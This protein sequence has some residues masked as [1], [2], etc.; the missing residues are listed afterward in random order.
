MRA[1]VRASGGNPFF[2]RE[3]LHALEAEEIE[4]TEASAPRVDQF[5][6]DTVL[7]AVLAHLARF[8]DASVA[9]AH[10][11]SVLGA[12]AQLRHAADLA[13][14]E[15]PVAAAGADALAAAGIFG[16]GEPL[17]YAHPLLASAVYN[18]IPRAERGLLHARAARVIASDSSP[19]LAASHLL[20]APASAD[21]WA[22]DILREAGRQ[23]L[24]VGA[25][26]PAARYLERALVEP[27]PP[28]L[29][30]AVLVELGEAETVAGDNPENATRHL[31]EA[32]ALMDDPRRRAQTI[33]R[34]GWTLQKAGRI[35]EAADVFA[36]GLAE[37][38]D[39]SDD[40]ATLLE[41]GY[42][43]AAW[44]DTTRAS[45]IHR[46]RAELLARRR[47]LSKE[48][49]RGLLA[50][51]TV[52][53][54][55]SA[56]S[57]E[58]VIARA[59]E[60][61][62]GGAL[63]DD[64]SSDSP[65]LWVAVGNLTWAD[66]LDLAEE[67][68]EWALEDAL[69][70]GAFLSAAMGYCMRAWP[71][72]YRGRVAEA[73]ADAQIALDA[74]SGGWGMLEPIARHW[75]G[76][77]LIEL[78]DLDAAEAALETE[79]EF[80]AATLM[81]GGLLV[82]RGRLALVRAEPALALE[83]L[84][85][86]GTIIVDTFGFD[87]PSALSWRSDAALAAAQLG[88][89]AAARAL[90]AEDLSVARRFGAPRAIGAS[91]RAAGLVEGGKRGAELLSAAVAVLEASPSRL[92]LARALVDLGATLRRAGRRT[93]ARAPLRQ[94]LELAERFGAFR[95]ERQARAELAATGSQLRQRTLSG[96]DSLTP[97]ERRVT[98]MAAAGMTNRG[99][100]Q[101]QFVTVNAVKWHL[102]NAYRKLDI[103]SREEL[104]AA[105][106]LATEEGGRP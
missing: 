14:V 102:R 28:E 11:A 61:L 89:V 24:A 94:G 18:N 38:S 17:S 2:L 106:G 40:L 31:E 77:S 46:R 92:E 66:A 8:P 41:V 15:L 35:A 37:Q 39:A 22:V 72:Y 12:D 96:L 55:F 95:L 32:L 91:L 76:L 80:T 71:R 6:P 99:I 34:L 4:A 20:L 69:R 53:E 16:S 42:L 90:A 19:E 85:H 48:A 27:P 62:D 67:A 78:D 7:R 21:P 9:L 73:A 26:A 45:E 93:E 79:G 29:R 1:C 70:R 74:A 49:E 82:A 23:A 81:Q 13:N 64:E 51:A 43:G 60:L 57:H 56:T 65:N 25:A 54:V 3:L 47:S 33:L 30:A 63:I 84:T 58:Q 68:I 98:E 88:D 101:S 100:A 44:L 105:L 103:T 83:V 87:N 50:Q 5:A 36:R 75:L 10:A 104:T 52:A 97:S 86:A 59:T